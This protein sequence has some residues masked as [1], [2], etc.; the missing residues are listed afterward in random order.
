MHHVG[1][2]RATAEPSGAEELAAK[3]AKLNLLANSGQRVCVK[4]RL[5]Q[6]AACRLKLVLASLRRFFQALR[7]PVGSGELIQGPIAH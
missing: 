4:L 6:V 2:A 5:P 1:Y 7:Q 3:L